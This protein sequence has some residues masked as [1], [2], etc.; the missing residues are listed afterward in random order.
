MIRTDMNQYAEWEYLIESIK[1]HV[2]TRFYSI[3]STDISFWYT[4]EIFSTWT[5]LE[6]LQQ[7]KYSLMAVKFILILIFL[8]LFTG[9]LGIFVTLTTFLNFLTCL[10][11]LTLLNYRL[12]VENLSYFIIVLIVCSQYSVLYSI[13]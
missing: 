7:E 12:T 11:A 1:E 6:Q 2:L 5:I 4:S 3:F 8:S 10:A 9:V 13:R